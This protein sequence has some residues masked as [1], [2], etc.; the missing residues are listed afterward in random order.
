MA[1]NLSSVPKN[2]GKNPTGYKSIYM[3][4]IDAVTDIP[5]AVDSVVSTD[6][7]LAATF[8]WK[9]IGFDTEGG[10]F[11]TTEQPA[12]NGTTGDNYTLTIFTAGNTSAQ[13]AA[14]EQ[15]DGVYLAIIGETK[16]GKF[17]LLFEKDRGMRLMRAKNDAPRAGSPRGFTFTGSMDFNNLPFEYTG[18]IAES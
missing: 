7:T 14:I 12:A 16:D 15:F 8:F 9:K 3:I 6:I 18:A 11:L 1:I 4:D 13:K 2:Q 17:E 5:A 10:A